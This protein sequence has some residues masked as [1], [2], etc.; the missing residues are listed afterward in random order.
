MSLDTKVEFQGGG[1]NF[2]VEMESTIKP[3]IR[4]VHIHDREVSRLVF[5]DCRVC[6]RKRDRLNFKRKLNPNCEG[7]YY[8]KKLL[9]H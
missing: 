5:L 7:L 6:K 4:K 1:V 9:F 3:T 8:R 2:K